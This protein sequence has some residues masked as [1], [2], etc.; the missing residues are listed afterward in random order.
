MNVR[1]FKIDTQIPNGLFI[2]S[3]SNFCL[4]FSL[5]NFYRSIFID[6]ILFFSFISI[7]LLNLSSSF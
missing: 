1:P 6:L 7:L 5:G 4:F 3:L 2:F